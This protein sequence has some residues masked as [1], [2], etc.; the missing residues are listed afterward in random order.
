[1]VNFLTEI[2]F[3]EDFTALG[4]E[5]IS[6]ISQ[7][8][9][10]VLRCAILFQVKSQSTSN[11]LT[12]LIRI[13]HSTKDL[14]VRWNVASLIKALTKS[15]D[16][17][18]NSVQQLI[19]LNSPS[20]N[21]QLPEFLEW[22]YTYNNS[23]ITQILQ[24]LMSANLGTNL[25]LVNHCL[26]LLAFFVKNHGFRMKYWLLRTGV[27]KNFTF[28]LTKSP[29]IYPLYLQLSTLQALKAMLETNDDYYHRY[30]IKHNLFAPLLSF[31]KDHY[32]EDDCITSAIL[33]IFDYVRVK[34]VSSI[35]QHL[36]DNFRD[37]IKFL[38]EQHFTC[39]SAILA[40]APPMMLMTSEG[41]ASSNALSSVTTKP[42]LT[43]SG[44]VSGDPMYRKFLQQQAEEEYFNE[45]Q[46]A[47]QLD[48]D[49]TTVVSK[50]QEQENA[51]VTLES[52]PNDFT[53]DSP[54]KKLKR[55]NEDVPEATES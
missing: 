13:F 36:S 26:D 45:I 18:N 50:D 43:P 33:D 42:S 25:D 22:L 14:I 2:L 8:D 37:E 51:P 6:I 54:S 32:R 11:L 7:H 46:D 39:F 5:I 10:S 35:M 24:P 27:P 16:P 47:N 49:F 29:A 23:Q 28:N 31:L 4:L 3:K 44:I 21:K 41:D 1:M 9:P 48:V 53:Q 34:G 15:P 55:S 40:K 17:S 20:N 30:F 52:F 38:D 19:Q 12:C